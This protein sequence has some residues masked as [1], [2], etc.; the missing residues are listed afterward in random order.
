LELSNKITK[1]FKNNNAL[2]VFIDEL[3]FQKFPNSTTTKIES[4]YSFLEVPTLPK[5]GKLDLKKVINS[6]STT[7]VIV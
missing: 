7:F 4:A 5:L 1:K 6:K 2:V 3:N